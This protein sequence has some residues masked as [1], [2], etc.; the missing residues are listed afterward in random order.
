MFFL[1][2]LLVI[3]LDVT[4]FA[5]TVW[6]NGSGNGLWNTPAN[7]NPD[8]VPDNNTIVTVNT[9]VGPVIP[10]G[11]DANC[12]EIRIGSNSG[13]P[14]TMTMSAGSL[15]TTNWLM[16]GTENSINQGVFIFNG[17][18]ITCG[19]Q[20]GGG[21]HLW[22]GYG[23]NGRLE[24][25][26]G[27]INV[28]NK[29]GLAF[30]AGGNGRALLY[31]GT[32]TA[33][34]FSMAESG[35][36]ATM[37]IT[38]GKLIISGNK[39]LLIKTYIAN[40]WITA[41]G[42]NPR[43]SLNLD[44]N[45]SNSGKTTLTATLPDLSKAWNPM[46]T[47][48][49]P[50]TSAAL[51][52]SSGS[53]A[54]SHD[55]YFGTDFD[56]VNN[57]A[58][59]AGDLNGDGL[60][61]T[62]DLLLLCQYWLED[63]NGS[64]PYAAVDEDNVVDMADF[65]RM[66]HNWMAG[67]DEVFKGNLSSNTFNVSS[68]TPDTMYYWRVDEV[69]SPQKIKGDVWTLHTGVDSSTL[70]GKIMCGYQGW[71][72]TPTDG[73]DKGW[74]HWGQDGGTFEPGSCVIDFWPDMSEME[75]DEKYAT[76]F[77]HADG[78]TAYVFSAY[79][80]KTVL[81]HFK[82]MFQYGID[83]VF[84]QRFAVSTTTPTG[85]N[86]CN[87]VL[88]SCREGANTYGRAYAVMY[89]LSGLVAGGT[90]QVIN[91]WKFLVD[92]MKITRDSNDR[93]YLH[94]NGKPVVTIWGIGFNDRL[95][96]LDECRSLVDFLKNDPNYGGN[97]VMIGVPSYWR[98][99]TRDCVNDVRVHEIALAADIVSP[100]AVGRFSDDVTLND[101]VNNVWAPDVN[102]CRTNNKEYLPVVFPGFSWYNLK[103]PNATFNAIPRRQGQF[104]W[105]QYASVINAGATMIYQAMFDEINEG[106]AI[107]KCTNDVP[108]GASPFVT[109]EG[110][111]S[112]EY[113]WLLGQGTRAL[114][115]EIS[116]IPSTR[117]A[118]P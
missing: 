88:Y 36:T 8:V 93:A 25:Y 117:P 53:D 103:Y 113:L 23:G 100:W 28:T 24:I 17:G 43:A 90:Q 98:T 27:T 2:T 52:W 65:A 74:K 67:A 60:V 75:P 85:L 3:S 77:Q 87:T 110:L 47:G 94:H 10:A 82:W 13:T 7:W 30:A 59:L 18:T 57:A 19:K 21:G 31:G 42:G 97:T 49:W 71:F 15:S 39:T 81:R 84:L 5:A 78:S 114:R 26:G 86:H 69:N 61:S 14:T 106:T 56:D 41:Y 83:G 40:G 20:G 118:R 102:W 46:P 76:P 104:L 89:D 33:S 4:A 111:P 44:Y 50:Q 107:F 70:T 105:S 92:S 96:T 64:E 54:V 9:Q 73:A 109:Y 116:P 35:Q 101:Y 115:G 11:T 1:C 55:V 16:V 66:A 72:N 45:V 38:A 91:D 68:L 12:L 95:Y 62:Y 34:D 63:P 112:D 48:T 58:R 108:V 51:T 80:R 99:L 79:N 29:F 32:I 37:D 6:D 22:I